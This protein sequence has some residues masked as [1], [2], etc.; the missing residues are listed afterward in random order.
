MKS[1]F[2]TI[3]STNISPDRETGIGAW[4]KDAFRRAK[5]ERYSGQGADANFAAKFRKLQARLG[6]N[7]RPS[8]ISDL[9]VKALKAKRPATRY[10]G[11]RL[12]GPLLFLR[13]VLSDRMLDALILWAFR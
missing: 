5:A 3:Y 7:R 6:K 8:I 13:R 2:G 12:A 11:G 9:I 1:A 4:S 10:H